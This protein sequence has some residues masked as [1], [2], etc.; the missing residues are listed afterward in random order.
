MSDP[1]KK[2]PLSRFLI[3]RRYGDA[4]NVVRCNFDRHGETI[5]SSADGNGEVAKFPRPKQISSLDREVLAGLFANAGRWQPTEHQGESCY[6]THVIPSQA[7]P[8]EAFLFR[9]IERVM[10]LAGEQDPQLIV[11]GDASVTVF[12]PEERYVDVF[13]QGQRALLSIP[14]TISR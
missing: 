11:N 2:L 13:A 8:K 12:V 5:E 3:P 4:A 10:K 1:D 6:F 9:A 14:S 7:M